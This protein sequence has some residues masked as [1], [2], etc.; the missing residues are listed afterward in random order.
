MTKTNVKNFPIVLG[1]AQLGFHYGIANKAGE[2]SQDAVDE[3]VKTAW[4]CGVAEFDTAPGYGRSE[5]VL[6]K[7]F[8]KFGIADKVKIMRKFN[9]DLDYLDSKIL[10]DT[11]DKSL[12]QLSVK[13]ISTLLL[14]KESLL[15][16][17]DKGLSKIMT[18]F[19]SSGKVGRIG[20]A[21]YSPEMAMRALEMN[22]MEV[23]VIPTNI[24]DRRFEKIGIF[25][26]AIKRN[27]EIYIR[28]VFLQGLLLLDFSEIPKNMEFALPE[29]Q[30][31]KIL[32]DKYKLSIKELA[33]G[34]VRKEMPE[35]KIIIGA[36]NSKQVME[37]CQLLKVIISDKVSDDIRSTFSAVSEKILNPSLWPIKN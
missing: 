29:L 1:T 18:D 17:W 14:H 2:L 19:V 22:G 15:E 6:G 16:L 34:Y 28:S 5:E 3:I 37:N 32:S 27:K 11:L 7:A 20:V 4:H 36:E 35:A 33:I 24:L 21:V 23:V 10:N 31:L 8:S 30:R 9:P 12:K 13:K 26:E 25:K